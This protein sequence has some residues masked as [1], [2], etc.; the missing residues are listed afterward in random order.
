[1][2]WFCLLVFYGH[3]QNFFQVVHIYGFVYWYV[4]VILGIFF[5]VVHM[6]IYCYFQI[7]V[8]WGGKPRQ[9]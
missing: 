1:M 2:V 9:L 5:Q 3:F 4:M 7:K 8:I 6:Y